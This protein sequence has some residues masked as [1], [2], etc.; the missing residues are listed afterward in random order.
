MNHP[1]RSTSPASW[2][3]A[4]FLFLIGAGAHLQAAGESVSVTIAN[5]PPGKTVQ[6]T[7]TTT[8]EATISNGDSSISNQGTVTSAAGG[9]VLTDDPDIVGTAN[10]TVTEAFRD[11]LPP[12]A[13]PDL[14][15][16]FASQS[17]KIPIADLLANDSSPDGNGPLTLTLVNYTGGNGASVIISGDQVLYDP[18]GYL[19]DDTFEYT[20]KDDI[21]LTST[22]TVTVQIKT[23]AGQTPNQVS[24]DKS[25]GDAVM[26]Y[27]G[28][29]GRQYRIQA[30]SDLINW[31][32]I[33]TV[34]ADAQ[35]RINFTEPG[36]LPPTRFYRTV[37]P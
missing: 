13:A 22:G 6:I 8:V 23:E 21:G 10:P 17:I 16:R 20:V 25:S 34:T 35:G 27:A 5:L 9:P 7:Y 33:G 36:P 4:A 18:A 28:I 31:E 11:P 1:F 2:L 30:S 26:T 19:G 3:S 15:E 12:V 14:V 29:P 32:V 37:F 24:F